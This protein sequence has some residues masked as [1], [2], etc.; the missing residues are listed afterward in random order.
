MNKKLKV[1]QLIDS[2]N[3]GGAEMMAVNI[4]NGL[5]DEDVQSH[6]C[7][8]RL[9]G[10]LKSK[11]ATSVGYLFLN[12]KHALDLRALKKLNKYIRDNKIAVIHAHS[13]SYFF[14]FLIKMRIPKIKIIWHD[15]YGHSENLIK[16]SKFPLNFVSTSFNATIS[17][18]KLLE[19][20]AEKFL[21]SKKGY[22]LSNFASL[23]TN[24]PKITLLKGEEG[25]R[26]VC[27]ANLRL[28]KD[29]LNLL[30]AFEIVHKQ[31]L[32][33]TLHLVGLDLN[34][35]Y[36][37]KIKSVIKMS[38]LDKSVFLYD[39]RSDI[40]HILAQATIG[41]L[42]SKSEGLPVSLLEYGLAKLPVVVTNVGDCANVVTNEING[43]VVAPNN[44]K[45]LAE[46][47][48]K[49]VANSKLRMSFGTNL[50][51]NIYYNFSKDKYIKKLISIYN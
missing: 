37:D 22:F 16:R 39:S 14:A 4:A 34:D 31:Y 1:I 51:E 28:Q 45:Q 18:N 3:P 27:L 32:D 46:A 35:T 38:S 24:I 10:S 40:T 19:Q 25:K 9:E 33:W 8:T 6:I 20:W 47:I 21:N 36:S 42:S 15:H 7:A 41:V 50:Y 23:D 13:S 17:V 44:D 49:L 30:K 2:L 29:H 48:L 11:I 5:A 43:L 12:K 26:I